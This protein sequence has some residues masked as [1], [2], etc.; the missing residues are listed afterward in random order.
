MVR[1]RKGSPSS[2]SRPSPRLGRGWKFGHSIDINM[3][4]HGQAGLGAIQR[5]NLTLRRVSVKL[6]AEPR[7]HSMSNPD[8]LSGHSGSHAEV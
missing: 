8:P 7:R 5:L 1:W 6:G 4:I 2:A 3:P